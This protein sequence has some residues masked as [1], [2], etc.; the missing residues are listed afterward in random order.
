MRRALWSR[1]RAGAVLLSK[2]LAVRA[3]CGTDPTA[4]HAATAA[5]AQWVLSSPSRAALTL[6]A[7]AGGWASRRGKARGSASRYAPCHLGRPT[8]DRR[9]DQSGRPSSA[10]AGTARRVCV[11]LPQGAGDSGDCHRK[12]NPG[13][14]RALPGCGARSTLLP[15]DA[16]LLILWDGSGAAGPR[17]T[18]GACGTD[19]GRARNW[20]PCCHNA[21]RPPR[22][23]SRCSSL[24]PLC[25]PCRAGPAR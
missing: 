15:G 12:D 19:C 20:S 3:S 11:R 21:R 13:H 14:N 9:A 6:C 25:A 22:A 23:G 24:R 16:H 17:A 5:V 4:G 1:S 8:G 2:R 10:G 7:F 18:A